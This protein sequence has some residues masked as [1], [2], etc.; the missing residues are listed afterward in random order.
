MTKKSTRGAH[1]L[2]KISEEMKQWSAMLSTELSDWPQVESKPMFG[3]TAFYRGEQIF[4]VLPKTRAFQTSNGVAFRFEAISEKL[5]KQ[6]R[7][8]ARV[9][10]N[11]IGK[12]WITFE[13]HEAKDVSAVLE[14][15]SRAYE[16]CR[17]PETKKARSKSSR[18]KSK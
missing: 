8:D 13:V 10:T 2:P 16:A 6:L 5:A 3:M 15:M 7:S 12:K 9:L 14:W 4:A 17:K 18:T 11:P 1:T